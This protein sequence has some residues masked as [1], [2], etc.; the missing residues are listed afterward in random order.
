MV[1][2][3]SFG[4]LA[5]AAPA[6]GLAIVLLATPAASQI[7]NTI[8]VFDPLSYVVSLMVIIV[9][10]IVAASVPALRAAR[11]DPIATLRND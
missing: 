7:A 4:L 5:G 3:V 11:V 10:C 1:R 6:A 8:Q 2:P 9:A